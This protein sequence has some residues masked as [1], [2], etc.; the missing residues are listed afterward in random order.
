MPSYSKPPLTLEQQLQHLESRGLRIERR[1]LAREVLATV[2]YYRLTAFW[3]PLLNTDRET[4]VPGA[5]FDAVYL[6][7]QF[8]SSLRLIRLYAVNH[9]EI[10]LRAG[11]IYHVSHHVNTGLWLQI[12]DLFVDPYRQAKVLLKIN[13]YLEQSKEDFAI[14]YRNKYKG[15]SPVPPAWI[16]LQ[17]ASFGDLVSLYANL[18]ET[19]IKDN[20]SERYRIHRDVLG[21]WLSMLIEVRNRSAHHNPV[22]NRNLYNQPMWP[23]RLRR[24]PQERW[25][26]TWDPPQQ[27]ELEMFLRHDRTELSPKQAVS[28]YAGLCCM[29]HMIDCINPQ[30]TFRRRL[31]RTK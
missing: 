27:S 12:L 15:E 8:D 18:K 13:G 16:A 10:G 3:S 25:V 9:I 28:V 6:R 23:K 11:L 1:T 14:H 19:R 5:S 7:Y 17:I 2:G 22:W 20:I 24:L 29:K 21:S 31:L 4:F 30:N 26:N